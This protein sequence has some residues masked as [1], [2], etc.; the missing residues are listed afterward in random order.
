MRA[1]LAAVL[2]GAMFALL[3]CGD[4][5]DDFAR[6]CRGQA[7]PDCLPYELAMLEAASLMP[8]GVPVGDPTVRV[9]VRV[10]LSRCEAFERN[11]EVTLQI[12]TLGES[13]RIFDLVTL[14]DDGRDGDA[15][16][17]DGL[18][19]KNIENPFFGPEIPAD[20]DVVLRWQARA[21]RDCSSGEC[22]GGTCRSEILETPY[23]TGA[24]PVPA[25]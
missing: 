20:A 11:H 23:H 22:V 4:D 6:S 9:D 5:G 19:E 10:E 24:R 1:G 14:R 16:A 21:P 13:P 3:G 12:R 18:I 15:M 7:V 17:G 2:L 25:G 8:D